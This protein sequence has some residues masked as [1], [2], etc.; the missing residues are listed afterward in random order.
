[1][2]IIEDRVFGELRFSYGWK[3]EERL[4]L[5]GNEYPIRCVVYIDENEIISEKARKSYEF[6][7][8]IENKIEN[9]IQKNISK[10]GKDLKYIQEHMRPR[11]LVIYNDG[12]SGI[13]FECDWDL[14]NGIALLLTP[15]IKLGTND[16]LL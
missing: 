9:I 15:D 14:D 1:M 10:I 11:T 7:K 2:K 8:K 4:N 13:V 6:Y 16:D 12:E 5:W 3:K